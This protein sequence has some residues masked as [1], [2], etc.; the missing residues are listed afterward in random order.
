MDGGDDIAKPGQEPPWLEESDR[1]ILPP[2][3]SDGISIVN[4][5]MGVWDWSI[6]Y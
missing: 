5:C 4:R 3:L 1:A 2:E 6:Q